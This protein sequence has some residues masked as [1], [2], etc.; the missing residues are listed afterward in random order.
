MARINESIREHAIDGLN[1]MIG[2]G[3]VE[4]SELHN[5]LFNE[6]YFIIGYY[7]AEKWLDENG[8]VFNAIESIKEYE[9]NNFGEVNT[10]FSNAESVANMYAY[11]LGEEL[12]GESR[13]LQNMWNRK[14]D[15]DDLQE[16]I[17]ELE[18]L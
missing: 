6:D 3:E 2:Y 14:L 8:G 18:D 4:A 9:Q 15:D 1:D 12:L 16:I 7:Q 10:D 13:E 5:R 17:D 11:I